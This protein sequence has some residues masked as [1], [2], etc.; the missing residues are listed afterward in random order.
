MNGKTPA[1]LTLLAVAIFVALVLTV[2]PY[3]ADWPGR[4][5][6]RPAQ[7]YIRAA[8][9]RDSVG[10]VRLST[11]VTPVVWALAAARTRPDSLALWAQNAEAWTGERRGDTTEVFLYSAGDRCSDAPIVFRFVGSGDAARVLRASSA[12]FDPR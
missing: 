10:L 9:R 11:S 12:C 7:R 1:Y 3:S 4:E 8:I 6:A 2:Q 5:F